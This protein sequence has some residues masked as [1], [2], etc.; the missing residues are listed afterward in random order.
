ML[1]ALW[2][3][4]LA[5]IL[6]RGD[7]F[8]LPCPCTS[9]PGRTNVFLPFPVFK[10]VTHNSY[11]H[12]FLLFIYI[13]R[14]L[15]LPAPPRAVLLVILYIHTHTVDKTTWTCS[16]VSISQVE[17]P[18]FTLPCEFP[19]LQTFSA[20][21]LSHHEPQNLGWEASCESLAHKPKQVC[22]ETLQ[23]IDFW[24]TSVVSRIIHSIYISV[25][26]LCSI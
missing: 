12:M 6:F 2:R 8:F 25:S 3:C 18:W 24:L 10:H 14:L 17:W 26:Y 15:K 7:G 20:R 5:A 13:L 23:S 9:F 22:S 19:I 1:L 16:R 4:G 21:R 11:R